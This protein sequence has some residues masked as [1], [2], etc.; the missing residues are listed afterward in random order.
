MAGTGGRAVSRMVGTGGREVG[1]MAG[2]GGR[3]VGRM[4]GTGGRAV[5]WMAGTGGRAVGRMSGTGGRAVDWM[6]G[7][8]DGYGKTGMGKK[9][10]RLTAYMAGWV[11]GRTNAHTQTQYSGYKSRVNLR[12]F[13]D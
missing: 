9:S 13:L 12:E 2:T 4:A 10:S 8:E 3:A 11:R 1:R 6:A 7:T 5:D